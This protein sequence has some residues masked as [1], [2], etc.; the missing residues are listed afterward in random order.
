[1]VAAI[2]VAVAAVVSEPFGPLIAPRKR[3]LDLVEMN[4][5][6]CL[7]IKIPLVSEHRQD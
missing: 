2:A 4:Y 1:M 5:Y 7:P 3:H 6:R